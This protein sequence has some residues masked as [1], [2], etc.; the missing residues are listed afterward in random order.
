MAEP[1]SLRPGAGGEAVRDLQRR[2]A[3]FGLSCEPDDPG[4]FAAG[5]E[6]AVRRFQAERG[7]RADGVVDRHTWAALV[8]SGFALG[9]RLLYFRQPNLRGDDVSAL[10]RRLNALG[11]DAGRPDGLFGSA[12][13][14]ALVEFQ[15]S[16]GLVGDG[17]CGP[18]TLAALDRVSG[19]AAGAV[20]TAR[21]RDA[22]RH[23]RR[24]IAGRRVFVATT[25]GLAVIGEALTRGLNRAGAVAVLDPSG[26]D[27][28]V[29]ARAANAFAAELFVGL[30]IGSEPGLRC[31]YFE[32][33]GFR[34]ELGFVTA[35]ALC[36]ELS[37]PLGVT[38]DLVGRSYP[39]LRET[40][41]AAVVC[42]LAHSG[43]AS[44][45]AAV[46]GRAGEVV[47]AMVRAIELAWAAPAERPI[48]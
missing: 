18:S 47:R 21:E 26:H 46:V 36:H 37:G 8:E 17:I 40:R 42:E 10:Q 23:G 13:Q 15:R 44:T 29:I 12:T 41:M 2:L 14:R 5:T 31:A 35:G 11:F 34:S 19:F 22:L 33:V 32:T 30:T 43:D 28:S 20:A 6:A 16:T 24:G 39:V 45:V 1:L 25:P 7:L 48:E 3:E 9:D 4:R 38:V 27:E